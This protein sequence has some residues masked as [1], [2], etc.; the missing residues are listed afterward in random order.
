MRGYSIAHILF[1]ALKVINI[2]QHIVLSI[3]GFVSW[4]GDEFAQIV[5]QIVWIF[6]APIDTRA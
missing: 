3:K 1:G 2:C 4:L 6:M 5:I